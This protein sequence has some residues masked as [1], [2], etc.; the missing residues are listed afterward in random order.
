MKSQSHASRIPSSRAITVMPLSRM[1]R[2]HFR[3]AHHRRFSRYGIEDCFNSPDAQ[4]E[5]PIQHLF[6]FLF[7]LNVWRLRQPRVPDLWPTCPGF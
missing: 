5:T 4:I 1:Q 3:H 7:Y 6:N 2:L